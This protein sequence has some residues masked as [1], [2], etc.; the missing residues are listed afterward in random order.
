MN[1]HLDS[2][3]ALLGLHDL[4]KNGVFWDVNTTQRKIDVLDQRSASLDQVKLR[5][6]IIELSGVGPGDSVVEI[7]CGTGA[8]LCDLARSVSHRGR[9]IGTDA[10]PAFVHAAIERLS[11]AGHASI[12]EV[13]LESVEKLSLGSESANACLAQTTLI[14]LP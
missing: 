12:S 11:K 13:K 8:L 9:V 1:R 5:E 3:S 14:H 2:Q 7:G 4:F 10:Q 6:R